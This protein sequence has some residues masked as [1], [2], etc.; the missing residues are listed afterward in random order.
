MIPYE[1]YM[2]MDL[3]NRL[4]YI[5]SRLR[6]ANNRTSTPGTDKRKTGDQIVRDIIFAVGMR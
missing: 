5:I 4:K 1:E 2:N 3:E 6:E